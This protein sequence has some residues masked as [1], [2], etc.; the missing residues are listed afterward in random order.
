MGRSKPIHSRITEVAA[1]QKRSRP[2]ATLNGSA[3]R[4]VRLACKQLTGD[5]LERFELERIAGGIEQ[6]HRCLFAG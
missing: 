2:M 3:A 1:R 4:T 5:I 6:K